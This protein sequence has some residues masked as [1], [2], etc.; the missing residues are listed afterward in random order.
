VLLLL[1]A[2]AV[3]AAPAPFA[4]AELRPGLDG[5]RG[6][7]DAV[8]EAVHRVIA[9]G[10]GS[11]SIRYTLGRDNYAVTISGDRLRWHAGSKTTSE[12]VV[13][14]EAGKIDLTDVRSRRTRRGIYKVACD[15]LAVCLAAE[16]AKERPTSFDA[17]H[18]GDSVYVLRRKRRQES[19]YATSRVARAAAG[20]VRCRGGARAISQDGAEG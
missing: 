13:R 19:P 14:I 18:E 3:V 1:A 4:K 10:R 20:V 17:E 9:Q 2:G 15:T 6:E 12:E 16:G 7:W 5:I 11:T 8:S